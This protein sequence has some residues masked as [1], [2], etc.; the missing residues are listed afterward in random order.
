MAKRRA[1][2]EMKATM[3]LGDFLVAYLQRAGVTHLFGL[4]GDLVLGLFQRFGHARGLDIVTFSHEPSVGFAADGYARSTR[5]LGVLC[6]TYGAGGHNV[7][8]PVAGAYAEQVPLL[9]VSGGPGDAEAKLALVHHQVK[10]V[11]A[12]SRIFSEVTCI[13]RTLRHPERAALEVHEVVGTILR[14]MRPGYLEIHRDWVDVKIPV[15]P[16]LREWNGR[17]ARPASHRRKLQEAVSDTL[18]RLRAAKKPFLVGGVELF[19]ERA[20]T[21]F[22][23]LAE[24]LGAPVATTVLAKGVFPMD[25][26]LHAGIHMGPFSHARIRKRMREADLVLA[27]GVQQTDLNLGAAKPQVAPEREVWAHSQRVEISYHQ[28]SDVT[29]KDFVSALAGAKL[30]RF[31]ER[32][33]Y[34][35]NLKPAGAKARPSRTLRIN[36]LLLEVNHFLSRHPGMHVVA[37]SGDMLFGGLEVRTHGGALYFAQGYYASMGFAIPAALGIE[38]GTGV[39]PLVLCGDGGFQMTGTEIAHAVGRGLR[40]LVVLVNNGG[41]GIF[42]PVTPRRELLEIPPWPYAELARQLGGRGF[43]AETPGELRAALEEA[44]ASDAF[45][46]VECRVPES[47][48]SPLSRRYIKASAKRAGAG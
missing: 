26:P 16:E 45:S 15:P 30:P 33:V 46:L 1:A 23:R 11:E 37:E 29:L 20:E 4:P 47:D 8:N 24:R 6:V 12:Q 36:D 9:V 25:H 13:A 41:W 21:D 38:I 42:R 22:R 32:V 5:R 2:T 43:V 39:R 31:R 14:E 34:A 40:P 35:D 17:F 19:R 27:L 18:E 28:Y 7:V 10:D 48:L 44:E 3:P